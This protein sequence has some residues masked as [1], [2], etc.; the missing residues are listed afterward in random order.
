[1]SDAPATQFFRAVRGSR[2][3]GEAT[4]CAFLLDPAEPIEVSTAR[5][6]W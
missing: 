2:K 5:L 4:A 1:M 3:A 6:S